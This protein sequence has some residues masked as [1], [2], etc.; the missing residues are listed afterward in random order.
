MRMDRGC[1]LLKVQFNSG[2]LLNMR[3]SGSGTM[4]GEAFFYF[5]SAMFSI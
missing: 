3:E 5:L 1:G 4:T 2:A